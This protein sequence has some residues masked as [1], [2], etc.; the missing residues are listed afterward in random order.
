LLLCQTGVEG[1]GNKCILE[2]AKY[3]L[4]LVSCR[5]LP[6]EFK[7]RSRR[8]QNSLVRLAHTI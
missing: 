1:D 5:K 7:N 2:M 3:T 6:P 4:V 8:I